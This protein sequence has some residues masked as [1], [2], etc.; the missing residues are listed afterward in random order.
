MAT[1]EIHLSLDSE[2]EARLKARAEQQGMTLETY[3]RAVL[4]GLARPLDARS[5]RSLPREERNRILATQA[6]AAAALYAADLAKPVE[7]RELTAFTALDGE[8][9]YE[10]T[11]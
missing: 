4:E 3:L 9:I 1:I 7:E 2:D 5:L 10:H 6:E 8:P 11:P